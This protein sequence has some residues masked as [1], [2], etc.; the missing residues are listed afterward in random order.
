MALTAAEHARV[1]AESK[2]RRNAGRRRRR[3]NPIVVSWLKDQ[4]KRCLFCSQYLAIGAES[5]HGLG[6]RTCES[7]WRK[8]EALRSKER[9]DPGQGAA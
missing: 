4:A 7:C 8:I 5:A 2:A 6:F 3:Q 9:R 1:K